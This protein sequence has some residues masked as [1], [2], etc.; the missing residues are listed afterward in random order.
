MRL[1][2]D[3]LYHFTR[4]IDVVKKILENGFRYSLLKEEIPSDM[5]KR[6]LYAICFCDIRIDE[7]ENHRN[8]YGNQA[9]VLTKG[10]GIRNNVSPVRYIHLNS[11]GASKNYIKLR[12]YY[13]NMRDFHTMYSDKV[14][15]NL[16]YLFFTIMHIEKKLKGDNIIEELKINEENFVNDYNNLDF[17]F[18]GFYNYL[19]ENREDYALL[20]TKY[21]NSL[22]F[23]IVELHNELLQRDLYLRN[24]NEDFLC[25]TNKK[26]KNKILYDER[27]WRAIHLETI[28]EKSS[29]EH[30][31]EFDNYY[32]LGF[33]PERFNL[34]FKSN[35][36][37]AILTESK[38]EKEELIK[39]LKSTEFVDI[40]KNIDE[41]VYELEEFEEK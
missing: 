3:N 32:K 31:K 27:E 12:N 33:L 38:K 9:I 23:R 24:Y 22:L 21:I 36:I 34:K 35:D 6:A 41:K 11:P 39:Y 40:Y 5:Y 1:S 19:K 18:A 4:E 26:V 25:P 15:F 7:T 30:E 17:E 10:W 28:T 8:C 29:Q 2:S 16:L 14:E 37:V 20:V 13:K